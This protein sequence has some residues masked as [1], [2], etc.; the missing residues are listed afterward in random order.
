MVEPGSWVSASEPAVRAVVAVRDLRDDAT[1]LTAAHL[2]CDGLYVDGRTPDDPEQ[3][4]AVGEA[5]GIGGAALVARGRSPEGR[6]AVPR[7]YARAHGLGVTTYP[8]LFVRPPGDAGA[9]LLPVLAGYAP[10]EVIVAEVRR[11]AGAAA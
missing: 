9:P 1:A 3:V 7:E 4:A 8:S 6:A 11:V 5:C 10:A 2:L